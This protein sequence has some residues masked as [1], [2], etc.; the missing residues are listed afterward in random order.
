MST[1]VESTSRSAKTV[2]RTTLLDLVWRVDH[3]TRDE[4]TTVETITDLLASGRVQLTGNFRDV[5]VER[6]L[7]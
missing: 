6:F 5:P 7:G 4:E 1:V 3:E 2:E